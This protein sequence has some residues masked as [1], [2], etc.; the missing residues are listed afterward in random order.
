[1]SYR[2][3]WNQAQGQSHTLRLKLPRDFFY[4]LLENAAL[5]GYENLRQNKSILEYQQ[6]A[7]RLLNRVQWDPERTEQLTRFPKRRAIQIGIHN[8]WFDRYKASI[9]AI[10]DATQLTAQIKQTI[11]NNEDYR[12]LLPA[13]YPFPFSHSAMERLNAL[14]LL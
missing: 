9:Q 13:E 1:M 6:D 5:T 11:E 14:P 4:E 2:N 3:S 7:A 8:S 12:P 10:E